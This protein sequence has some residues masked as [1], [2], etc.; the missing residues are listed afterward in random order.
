MPEEP[1]ETEATEEVNEPLPRVP[2]ARQAARRQVAQDLR[3]PQT[4]EERVRD[5]V[6]FMLEASLQPLPNDVSPQPVLRR[7]KNG[8]LI[9]RNGALTATIAPD[10]TVSF[11][12]RAGVDVELRDPSTDRTDT[13]GTDP[14]EEEPGAAEVTFRPKVD[15]ND[16]LLRAAGDDPLAAKKRRFLRLT[17]EQRDTMAA[18]E[19]R[20]A[21]SPSKLLAS[22]RLSQV[23]QDESLSFG[24]KRQLFFRLWDECE[25]PRDGDD[26]RPEA[27]AGQETREEI[28]AFIQKQLPAGSPQ[29]YSDQ[30]LR[31]LNDQRESRQRFEPYRASRVA[32]AAP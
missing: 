15:L 25:E 32:T 4:E 13:V 19:A 31:A 5:R 7:D 20:R 11:G 16:I 8:N 24:T 21:L 3:P 17:E 14:F 28:C 23:W 6:Q 30:E 9:H 27:L 12:R 29:A 2:S 10:G 18:A 22:R 26:G 1:T